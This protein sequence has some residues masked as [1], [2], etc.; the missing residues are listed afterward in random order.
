MDQGFEGAEARRGKKHEREKHKEGN[1]WIDGGKEGIRAKR[2]SKSASERRWE[3]ARV[4]E[5]KCGR[6][7]ERAAASKARLS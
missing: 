4:G 7:Q 5:S 2:A 6:E 1:G 3:R